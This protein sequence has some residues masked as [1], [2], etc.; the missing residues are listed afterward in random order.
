MYSE[1]EDELLTIRKSIEQCVR[2]DPAGALPVL[3]DYAVVLPETDQ[4]Y[5]PE[6]RQSVFSYMLNYV[7]GFVLEALEASSAAIESFADAIVKVRLQSCGIYRDSILNVSH[8][9]PGHPF[10]EW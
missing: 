3:C 9:L 10:G 5:N 1:D 7:D 2:H 6:L 8:Y 4:S